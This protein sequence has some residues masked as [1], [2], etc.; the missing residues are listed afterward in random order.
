M[1]IE[2]LNFGRTSVKHRTLYGNEKNKKRDGY[3]VCWDK[4]G[5]NAVNIKTLVTELAS[6]LEPNEKC[7]MY[8]I[9][10]DAEIDNILDSLCYASNTFQKLIN[11][12]IKVGNTYSYYLMKDN[13]IMGVA[14]IKPKEDDEYAKKLKININ[15]KVNTTDKAKVTKAIIDTLNHFNDEDTII[16]IDYE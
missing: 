11:E 16:E 4:F 3:E 9:N 5:Y 13:M 10:E 2:D 15:T 1:K 8:Y 6:G 12:H 7:E 14:F